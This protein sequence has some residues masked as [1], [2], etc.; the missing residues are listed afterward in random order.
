MTQYIELKNHLDG[1]SLS[2]VLQAEKTAAELSQRV[3]L[4]G[5]TVRDIVIGRPLGNPELDI[6]VV[7]DERAFAEALAASDPTSR[8]TLAF[9]EHRTAKIRVRG[10]AVEV[11][12]AR[13]DVYDPWGSLPQITPVDS[14]ERD[15][16]RRDFTINAM[17]ISINE[18]DFGALIDPHDGATDCRSGI[19]QVLQEDSFREDPTRM[20][21]GIR[22]VARLGFDFAPDSREIIL[23]DAS[24]MRS[25]MAESPER[26]FR[27]FSLWFATHEN[28]AEIVRI[29]DETRILEQVAPEIRKDSTGRNSFAKHQ[30][31]L[32]ELARLASVVLGISSRHAV[33]L[34]DRMRMPRRWREIVTTSAKIDRALTLI[35]DPEVRNSDIVDLLTPFPIEVVEAASL[36]AT[37][38][39]V[40]DRLKRFLI[41]LRHVR[42]FCDGDDLLQAGVPQGPQI[43]QFLEELLERRLNGLH[44]TRRDEL[45][46]VCARLRSMTI[47]GA[48]D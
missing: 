39:K 36:L 17:A 38:Q 5:G 35:A 14:I 10:V 43:G 15:L 31:N 2:A 41:N 46:Y 7:G 3:Y 9:S 40:K 30:R 21:R 23:C 16:A 33:D 34:S 32:D 44:A 45:N 1:D 37:N 26:L 22:F 24:R 25:F 29:A 47:D 8:Q 4:V 19:L 27:E 6:T 12:A 18:D 20:M 28:T 48:T 13:S 11:A 42:T